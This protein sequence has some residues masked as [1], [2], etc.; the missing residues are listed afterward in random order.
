MLASMNHVQEKKSKA[1]DTGTEL[2]DS[3]FF[4]T[5]T[6]NSIKGGTEQ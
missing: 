2:R 4:A 1:E 3:K 6:I 5:R